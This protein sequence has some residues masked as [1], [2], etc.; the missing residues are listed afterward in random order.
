MSR[1]KRISL[2]Q[3][4]NFRK[5]GIGN[6][7]KIYFVEWDGKVLRNQKPADCVEVDLENAHVTFGKSESDIAVIKLS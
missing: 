6:W 5:F 2:Y 1:Q 3:G 7:K 4:R